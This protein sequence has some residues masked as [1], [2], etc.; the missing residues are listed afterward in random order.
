MFL[1]DD[2]VSLCYA[3]EE[4]VES[5]SFLSRVELNETMMNFEFDEKN[6]LS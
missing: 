6:R 4:L 5:V 1:E 3:M 2:S